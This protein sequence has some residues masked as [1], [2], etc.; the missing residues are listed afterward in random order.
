[1]AAVDTVAADMVGG[2]VAAATAADMLVVATAAGDT[3]AVGME[4]ATG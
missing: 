4:A 2:M 3:V 1:V